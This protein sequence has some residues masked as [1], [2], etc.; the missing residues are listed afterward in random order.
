[1]WKNVFRGFKMFNSDNS[2][3]FSFSIN[4]Q[5]TFI[6]I[7]HNWKLFIHTLLK[8]PLWIEH[9]NFLIEGHL[10]LRSQKW[11]LCSIR[12]SSKD[13]WINVYCV[14]CNDELK[15]MIKVNYKSIDVWLNWLRTAAGYICSRFLISSIILNYIILN[16]WGIFRKWPTTIFHTHLPSPPTT[17]PLFPLLPPFNLSSS[18]PSTQ[19]LE[20]LD[21]NSYLIYSCI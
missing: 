5:V 19:D 11:T 18:P 12:K 3:M 14:L 2:S 7:Y 15:V 10:K 21:S 1:M 17:F 9:C 6:E 8:I 20:N 4:A 13:L 16:Y